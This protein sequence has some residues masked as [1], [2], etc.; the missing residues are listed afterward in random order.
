MKVLLLDIE[1]SPNLA[2]VWGLWKQNVGLNQLLENSHMLSWAA[3]WVD[4]SLMYY[5]DMSNQSERQML[6]PLITMLNEADVVV[7]HNGDKFDV[8]KI[9]TRCLKYGITPPAPYKSVDTLKVAKRYFAF[10]SNRLDYIA[11]YLGVGRKS[12]HAKFPGF[13]LWLGVMDNNPEAWAEMKKYNIMDV[14][15][16]EK[17]YL[18]LL[19]WITTHPNF[20]VYSEEEAHQCPKCGSED[21]QRRG[22]YTTN[23]SKFQRFRCNSCGGWSRTRYNETPKDKMK[24]LLTNIA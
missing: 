3:K 12:T 23:V 21:L 2:H 16:L 9:N 8:K 13:E 6:I 5:E 14:E 7:A 22:F 19:P 17:V 4:E 11:K 10:E 1:T 24:T 18:E 20:G 15:V